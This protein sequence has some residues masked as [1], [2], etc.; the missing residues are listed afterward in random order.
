MSLRELDL[1][2]KVDLK[3]YT[4]IK[5]GGKAKQFFLV[6]A[7]ENLSQIIKDFG[8]EFYLLGKGSNLLISDQ[9]INQ[10][11]VKLSQEFDY[12]RKADNYLE[13]GA[14]TT[15]SRL[16]TY[17]R[18]N[19]L[20]G[21]ENLVGI[22]A[23]VGG[24]L[25]M[26]GSSYGSCISSALAEVEVLDRKGKRAT[27]AKEQIE[28]GYRFSSLQD[29]VIVKARFN[30][31]GSKF[32]EQK[33]R[34][35]LNKR[36][37]SQDLNFPSCGSIFKNPAEFSAGHLIDSCTLK[38]LKKGDA[39]ISLKHANFIINLRSAKYDDVDYLIRKIKEEVYKKY[40]IILEE[41]IKRWT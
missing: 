15:L 33:M 16:L 18:E 38:G 31:S 1:K 27:L 12:I 14:A 10:P 35:S 17:C 7:L 39:Q 11:V 32:S 23:S 4:S 28:F 6:H 24:L 34:E 2:P 36:F 21:L 20:G 40:S 37:R 41:E 19:N 25:F 8:P 29:K 9:I 26:N 5:I 22:P 3:D 13:A 30:F